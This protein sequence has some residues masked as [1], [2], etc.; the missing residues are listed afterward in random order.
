VNKKQKLAFDQENGNQ[1]EEPSTSSSSLMTAQG[2]SPHLSSY[3]ESGD[4]RKLF[5]PKLYYGMDCDVQRVVLDRI[6]KLEMVN[7]IAAG[8]RTLVNGGNQDDLCS[9]H[10]IFLIRHQS[11][12]LACAV[13]KFVDEV[14]DTSRWTWQKCIEHSIALM[15]NI[16]VESYTHWR[17]LAR[18]HRQLAYSPKGT[19]FKSPAPKSRLPPFFIE[20]PDAMDAFKKH[21]VSILKELTMEEC[22]HMCSKH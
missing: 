4:S 14:C 11:M 2:P 3:W 6:E 9:E 10:D 15:N 19:F 20:N 18:W 7:S 5:A 17:P 12:Y 21:G 16:G 8:W 13:Q 22:T 1:I